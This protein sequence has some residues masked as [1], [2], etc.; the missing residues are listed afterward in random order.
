MRKAG[1]TEGEERSWEGGKQKPVAE[2]GRWDMSAEDR[3]AGESRLDQR[4]APGTFC[5]QS[6]HVEEIIRRPSISG[7]SEAELE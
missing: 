1:K 5:S 2:E 6:Q 4:D 3:W 7:T